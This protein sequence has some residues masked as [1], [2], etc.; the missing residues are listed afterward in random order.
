MNQ[1]ELTLLGTP[2]VRYRGETLKVQQRHLAL[3]AYVAIEHR[4]CRRDE[5]TNIL[6]G[7]G[8]SANLRVALSKLRKLPGADSWLKDGERLELRAQS[9]LSRLE[10]SLEQATLTDDALSVLERVSRGND[11]FL[12]GVKAPTPAF[13]SWLDEQRGRGRV[14]SESLLLRAATQCREQ[15]RLKQANSFCDALLKRDLL[16][17]EACR[18]SMRLNVELGK[19]EAAQRIYERFRATLKEQLGGEPSE[20]TETLHKSL[21]GVGS[22]RGYLLHPGDTVPGRATHL[23]G[24][25]SLLADVVATLPEAALL[26]GL[27]GIGKTALAAEV[28][29]QY[30]DRASVLW[31]EA[32][33]SDADELIGTAARLLGDA[34]A[35]LS[36]AAFTDEAVE[37]VVID[38][39]QDAG[40]VATLRERLPLGLALLVTSRYRYTRFQRFDVSVLPRAEAHALL[41][42][43]ADAPLESDESRGL[44]EVLGDHPYALRLAG[45]KLRL[46]AITPGQLLAQLA[47][48]P[49]LLKAPLTW[50]GHESVSALLQASLGALSDDAYYAFLGVGALPTTSVSAPLL[51][52]LLERGEARTEEALIELHRRALARRAAEPGSDAVRYTLHDLSHSFAKENNI[53]RSQSVL[54]AYQ[55]FTARHKREF[56]WLDVEIGNL[57][58]VLEAAK[59]ATRKDALVSVMADLATGDAYF[60]SHGY[61]ARAL[62]LLKTAVTWAK[63]AGELE[64]AHHFATRL[65]DTLRVQSQDFRGAADAYDEGVQ[66][67]RF[68]R[69]PAREVILICLR[70]VCRHNLGLDTE[71]DF[72]QAYALAQETG[73]DDARGQVLQNRSYI[74]SLKDDWIAVETYSEQAVATARKMAAEGQNRAR[75]DDL[76]FYSLLTLGEA[77]RERGAF[78]EAIELREEALALAVKRDNRLWQAHAC[79]DLGETYLEQGQ[80]GKGQI[81]LLKAITTY[82]ENNAKAEGR[83]VE[84]IM[85]TNGLR[86]VNA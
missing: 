70:A 59:S 31:L 5:L 49:H 18:L 16:N 28:T 66:L 39:A 71:A 14:L 73:D 20:A 62:S 13:T 48:A 36:E 58:G 57:V 82:K 44:C 61:T 17:E 11:Q 27:G 63:E 19:P 33:S 21:L 79:R 74:S 9:D 51:A 32:G 83:E 78:A 2:S 60:T 3:I 26:H 8:R 85:A 47:G 68:L 24:R 56:K 54:N 84:A 25:A 22:A 86:A 69:N 80:V 42:F 41:A 53:V 65:G 29:S 81:C 1:L 43:E 7:A 76:L 45:A 46:D 77:K 35:Q 4:A 34:S 67:A 10:A 72:E 52:N 23:F 30:L 50:R 55:K 38:N 12:L 64:K 37:L 6:W 75:A 15:S 40:A